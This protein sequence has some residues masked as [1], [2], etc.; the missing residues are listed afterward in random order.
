MRN[1]KQKILLVLIGMLS[2]I[3]LLEV[4]LRIVGFGY[5]NRGGNYTTILCLGDSVTKGEGVPVKKNY[6]AQLENLLNLSLKEKKFQVINS[7]AGRVNTAIVLDSLPDLI[8]RFKPKIIILMVGEANYLN[9]WGYKKYLNRIYGQEDEKLADKVKR[10]FKKKERIPAQVFLGNDAEDGNS[11]F[12]TKDFYAVNS[13]KAWEYMY[14]GN[15][16]QALRL[17]TEAI[18]NYPDDPDN[19]RGLGKLSFK[20]GQYDRALEWFDKAIEIKPI[21]SVYFDLG[22]TYTYMGNSAKAIESFKKAVDL[23]PY[24]IEAYQCIGELYRTQG[25]FDEALNFFAGEEKRNPEVSDILE[26]FKKEGDFGEKIKEWIS[27]DLNEIV[28]VCKSNRVKLIL[29]NY[30]SPLHERSS[31]VIRE[32]A[33]RESLLFVDIFQSFAGLLGK[34]H[35]REELFVIDHEHCTG[36]GYGIIA[37]DIYAKIYE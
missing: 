12:E 32:I 22:R 24:E 14:R 36:K 15:Y 5:F 21:S 27:S 26:L 29:A 16:E 8:D 3:F 30:P 28:R 35:K 20:K 11:D 7:G 34:G 37:K 9:F 25:R 13:D 2:V 4:S 6:P 31:A 19:Y 1:I 23:N 18:K 33:L 17:F 10:I